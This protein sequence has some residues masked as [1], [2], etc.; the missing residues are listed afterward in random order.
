MHNAQCTRCIDAIAVRLQRAKTFRL[1]RGITVRLTASAEA[2]AVRRSLARRRKADATGIAAAAVLIITIATAGSAAQTGR[3]PDQVLARVQAAVAGSDASAANAALSEA[4]AAYPSDPNL[5]NLAGV[6]AAQR[7]ATREAEAHFQKAIELAPRAVAAYE[8]L[9]R[10]YQEEAATQPEAAQSAIDLYR[11]WLR[12]DAS[13]DDARYQLAFLLT[14]AGKFDEGLTEIERLPQGALTQPHVAVV[15]VAALQGV[16][17]SDKA[18]ALA[19]Q[20]TSG[21]E[22]SEPDVLRVVPAFVKASTV[23]AARVLLEPLAGRPGA[24]ADALRALAAVKGHGGDFAGARSALERAMA[25]TGPNA[26]MLRELAE[27]AYR[28]RDF[29]G[30]LVYLA[31][32]RTLEP[33]NAGIHFLFG[34]VCIELNLGREAY[35]ALKK[36]IE[37]DPM[38][39]SINY[40]FG[41]VALRM[42]ERGEALPYFE[43]YV[44]L[45]PEDPRGRFALGVA[46]FHTGELDRA[47]EVLTDA[48]THKETSAGAHY[49]LARIARQQN[50]LDSALHH[51]EEALR[52]APK[53]P[54]AHAE[55]GQIYTRLGR[56][57]DAEK[58]LRQALAL[59]AEN[60]LATLNLTA[61]YTRTRDPRKD[62]MATRLEGLQKKREDQAQ[63]LLRIIQV[64]PQ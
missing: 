13:N 2:T 44:Q 46:C 29:E 21:P 27:L 42:H 41:A 7:G 52:V 15:H 26:L 64:V 28:Q 55:L 48:A 33:S 45:V 53:E 31:Q 56:F 47:K 16:G 36:A 20:L 18:V 30:A 23:E 59:D 40:A 5:H 54:D 22:L 34:I 10:L 58:S 9:G 63:E 35:D 25:M 1:R 24:S 17:Q 49:Y 12:L 32:A 19:R 39:P 57:D 3:A 50:D 4:L 51:I 61:L 8:N 11:R 37:L 62:E 43:R 6:V 60:Y 38:N 14:N